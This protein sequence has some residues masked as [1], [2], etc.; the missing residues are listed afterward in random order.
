MDH[1]ICGRHH[2]QSF[3]FDVCVASDRR[4]GCWFDP[5]SC[6]H[7]IRGEDSSW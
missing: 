7:L 2:Q 4:D 3:N 1:F 5:P 6:P